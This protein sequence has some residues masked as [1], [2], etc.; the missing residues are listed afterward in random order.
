LTHQL[1]QTSAGAFIVL[2]L[3]QVLN[4][5]IDAVGEQGYLNFRGTRVLF[6][7]PVILDNLRLERFVNTHRYS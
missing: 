6:A 1:E 3:V 7:D 2:V 5:P 4:Q